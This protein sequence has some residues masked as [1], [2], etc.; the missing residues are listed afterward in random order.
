[1]LSED[2]F[3]KI[4]LEP[5]RNG[6]NHLYIVS[7][8]ATAAMAFHHM[9]SI[10]QI[11]D[12]IKIDLVVGMCPRDGLTVSNHNGFKK[13]VEDD[14]AGSFQ[15]SYI[16]SS[17][18]VHSKVYIWGTDNEPSSGFTGSANYTQN[19]FRSRQREVMSPCS[20]DNAFEYYQQLLPDTIYC[21]HNDAENFIQIYNDN[22]TRRRER[23]VEQEEDGLA[24]PDHIVGLPKVEI[25]FLANDGTL[26]DRSG[27]NWGQR[28]EL[29]RNPNQAY[30][31]LP[32]TI[33]RTDFFPENKIHF[34]VLTDDNKILICTR[35]QANG[36]AVE[37]PQNNSLI[38]VYFRNRL[39]LPSGA[40]VTK[41]DLQNYGRTNVIFY[42]IDDETYYMDFAV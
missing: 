2:L 1:M 15:C 20:V 17:P 9:E 21:T 39:G 37:T 29:N 33:Y 16:M 36:K 34:T 25:S 31:R 40:F 6:A 19:A 24:I 10:R 8:Y 38:G 30:I 7:G 35:A 26:P 32:S 42:K 13:L 18:A 14:Y 27:L 41:E 22:Y 12:D 3:E 28:P 11:R 5:V 4:L 23:I